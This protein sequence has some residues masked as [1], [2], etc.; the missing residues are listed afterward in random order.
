MPSHPLPDEWWKEEAKIAEFRE[1]YRK[2]YFSV[3]EGTERLR[4]NGAPDFEKTLQK[5]FVW[6]SGM[7]SAFNRLRREDFPNVRYDSAA[8][9]HRILLDTRD[10]YDRWGASIADDPNADRSAMLKNPFSCPPEYLCNIALGGDPDS[11]SEDLVA[12]VTRHRI[13]YLHQYLEAG[14]EQFVVD[15]ALHRSMEAMGAK[16]DRK[17]YVQI[18]PEWAALEEGR[19]NA[20]QQYLDAIRAACSFWQAKNPNQ[21]QDE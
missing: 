20:Q 5:S 17:K 3:Y 6:L 16:P 18:S 15:A 11:W 1:I 13:Y 2:T 9:L 10:A 7:S 14:A 19:R 21:D 8:E 4:T 12:E